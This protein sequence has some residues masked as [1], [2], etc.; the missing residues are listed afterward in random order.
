M[1]YYAH[2]DGERKQT[3]KEHLRGTA[4][5]AEKFAGQFGKK[6]WGFCC[7]ALHDIGKYSENIKRKLQRMIVYVWIIPVQEHSFVWK[8]V[9]CMD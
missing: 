4:E 1:Q 7:G 2:T 5:L 8:K 3:L 6:D 9:D